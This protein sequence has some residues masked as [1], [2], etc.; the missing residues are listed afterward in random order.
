MADLW[1]RD[2]TAMTADQALPFDGISLVSGTA[3]ITSTGAGTGRLVVN[4]TV[5]RP[6]TEDLILGRNSYRFTIAEL[7]DWVSGNQSAAIPF[8]S[9]GN[10]G[11]EITDTIEYLAYATLNGNTS[12]INILR[13]G[14]TP[15]D[16]G[17][18]VIIFLDSQGVLPTDVLEIYLQKS[19]NN[20]SIFQAGI[21]NITQGNSVV[22]FDV[23]AGSD[24]TSVL[25][26]GGFC[27][28]GCGGGVSVKVRSWDIDMEPA[29]PP[30]F[31]GVL[32]RNSRT[33]SSVSVRLTAPTGGE[34]TVT[35]RI[36]RSLTPNFTPGPGNLVATGASFPL[37]YTDNSLAPETEVYFSGE[38]EDA[39]GQIATIAD[40]FPECLPLDFSDSDIP[41]NQK[42]DLDVVISGHSIM[43]D[44][45]S[46]ASYIQSFLAAGYTCNV[47]NTA[48]AT[49]Q[50][51]QF[52]TDAVPVN[53]PSLTLN[54]HDYTLAQV[55][56][57]MPNGMDCFVFTEAINTIGAGN[58]ASYEDNAIEFL[59]SVATTPAWVAKQKPGFRIILPPSQW[60]DP[61]RSIVYN[62]SH[63]PRLKAINALLPG[64]AAAVNLAAGHEICVVSLE[65]FFLLPIDVKARLR[66]APD[67][68][69]NTPDVGAGDPVPENGRYMLSQLIGRT[70]LRNLPFGGVRGSVFG[71][72]VFKSQVFKGSIL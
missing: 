1:D 43:L 36:Y 23:E 54:L 5:S 46:P 33:S 70:I 55:Q 63:I 24:A 37:V 15:I 42:R 47:L 2:F 72:G 25:Q 35:G 68:V 34:G 7:S 65:P 8:V 41:H 13:D 16:S 28:A 53:P 60:I 10:I 69:H 44:M 22:E 31:P 12:S 29:P 48:Y 39:E 59:T 51:L 66:N 14:S 71:G 58:D 49:R 56:A 67:G 64:I 11:D 19:A 17:G 38:Y 32:E 61:A 57:N 20:P 18:A 27:R 52:R 62:D 26:A 3:S 50:M 9:L 30:L 40:E 21:R 45:I 4:G 6:V